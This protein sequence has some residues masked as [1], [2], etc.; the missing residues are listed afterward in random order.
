MVKVIQNPVT[1]KFETVNE[2]GV[3]ADDVARTR[4]ELRDMLAGNVRFHKDKLGKKED[5]QDLVYA[6]PYFI[7]RPK[8]A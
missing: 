4:R 3:T 6:A 1:G 5:E 2:V 7:F 8:S